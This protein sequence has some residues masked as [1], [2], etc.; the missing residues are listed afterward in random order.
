MIRHVRALDGKL[1][2]RSYINCCSIF[3]TNFS[4]RSATMTLDAFYIHFIIGLISDNT[5]SLTLV[6]TKIPLKYYGS[7]SRPDKPESN[8]IPL[9]KQMFL[10][11]S[12]RVLLLLGR[13]NGPV[14]KY[15]LNGTSQLLGFSRS[16]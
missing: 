16:T 6:K 7:K 8:D 1:A 12:H 2:Q 13:T 10:P 15:E 9:I 11:L 3:V 14:G 4:S 5:K